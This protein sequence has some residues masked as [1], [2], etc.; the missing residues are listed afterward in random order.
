VLRNDHAP[1]VR[2]EQNLGGVE[3]QSTRGG[4]RPLDP[5]AV[6]LTRPHTWNEHVPVVISTVRCRIDPNH[7]GRGATILSVEEQEVDARGCPREQTEVDAAVSNRGAEGGASTDEPSL[8]HDCLKYLVRCS[9]APRLTP[10]D[11]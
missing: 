8:G 5:V 7:A 10:E 1:A 2:V 9:Q 4:R 11:D 6:E 3:P